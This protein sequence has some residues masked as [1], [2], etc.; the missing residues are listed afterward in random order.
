MYMDNLD[1]L[2]FVNKKLTNFING[3]Q[4][5]WHSKAPFTDDL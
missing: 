5:F 3:P 1:L 2:G 4:I